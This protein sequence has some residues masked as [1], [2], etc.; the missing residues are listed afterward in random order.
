MLKD[1]KLPVLSP[2]RKFIQPLPPSRLVVGG[3]PRINSSCGPH[4]TAPP[5]GTSQSLCVLSNNSNQKK[6]HLQWPRAAK[7]D[8]LRVRNESHSYRS[9]C[10]KNPLRKKVTPDRQCMCVRE[11]ISRAA[12]TAIALF[13]RGTSSIA[14]AGRPPGP[15]FLR[16]RRPQTALPPPTA[17]DDEEQLLLS[18]SIPDA[19]AC[20][21]SSRCG[22]RPGA[23]GTACGAGGVAA[24]DDTMST[25]PS[26]IRPP[27]PRSGIL[28]VST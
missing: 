12:A 11:P 17:D 4:R 16:R 9:H 6:N 14:A 21:S 25:D 28:A 7:E 20:G 26:D 19:A 27:P 23:I 24:L 2:T 22:D 1:N 15:S 10:V 18:H 8:R 3:R 13:R 5:A